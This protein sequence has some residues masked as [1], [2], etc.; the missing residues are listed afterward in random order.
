M[1]TVFFLFNQLKHYPI[2]VAANRDEYHNRPALPLQGWERQMQFPGN[3][4][5]APRD[6]VHKGTW[7]GF[8]NEKDKKFAVLTNIRNPTLKETNKISRGN[9][10]PQ[11]LN[12]SL[13]P[14][15]YLSIL[16]KQAAEY[17]LFN[18]IFGNDQECYYFH[19]FTGE[20]K[21]LW[22]RSQKKEKVYGL[23]NGKLNSHWPK[24]QE[25]I[26]Y[27]SKQKITDKDTSRLLLKKH[28]QDQTK[29]PLSKLPITG[30][31][32]EIEV[33]LSSLFIQNE[34]Y[35]TRSTT[36]FYL[37]PYTGT[38][39]IEE[40]QYHPNGSLLGEKQIHQKGR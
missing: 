15:V 11:F 23:S 39:W 1:C 24:V 32:P 13:S 7:F 21:L 18:L 29:H 38:H 27:F 16:K 31:S 22:N 19:S 25:T 30:V 28:M 17:H 37:N 8:L 10:I 5:Y 3:S 26:T 6:E 4:I 40:T 12:Y 34:A 35:G 9:I 20:S 36:L 33:F 2:V 14:R